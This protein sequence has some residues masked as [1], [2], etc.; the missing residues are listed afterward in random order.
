MQRRY[1]LDWLRVFAFALLMLFHTGMMFSTWDWHVKNLETSETFDQVMRWVHQWRMPLLFFISGSAVWF[2]MDHYST[3]RFFLERQKRLLLP[4]VF[5]MLVVIPPQVYFERLYHEQQYSSFWDFYPTI[6]STGSYPE[7]NLS[8]HHLWYVPYIWAYSMLMF[9]LFVCLRS[10]RGRKLLAHGLGWLERPWWLF[11]LFVPSAVSDLL[12]RPFWPSDQMNLLNDWANFSH[13]LSFFVVGFLL[14]SGTPVY[15]VIARHRNKFLCAGIAAFGLLEPVWMGHW[16]FPGHGVWA[17]RL[18]YNFHIWMWLLTALGYGRRYLSFNHRSLRYANEAVYPFYILHQTVIVILAYYLAYRNWSIASKFAVVAS[19]TFLVTWGLYEFC[20]KRWSLLRVSFGMKWAARREP[21]N[22]AGTTPAQGPILPVLR[23]SAVLVLMATTGF[24]VLSGCSAHHGKLVIGTL[25]ARSLEGNLLGM[26]SKQ[27]LAIYLPPSYSE[28]SA[29]RFP[30]L[31][32]L[33]NFTV[34]L[35]RYTGGSFQGFHLREAMD[36]QIQNGAAG[37]MIVVLPNALHFLGG[38]WYKTSPLTGDWDGY[39][40]HDL[41]QYVDSHFRTI[42]AAASRG[43]AGHGMGGTGAVELALRHP[44]VFGCVYALSPAVFDGNA[45]RDAGMLSERHLEHWR[46]AS[47][48]WAPL[49]ENARRKAFRDFIQT[50]LNSP[51]RARFWE[52]LCIS[53]AAAVSP[54][55]TL[56]YPHIRF[57]SPGQPNDPVLWAR[58]ANGLGGWDQKLA[59]Y[60]AR[61][62]AL[63]AITIEYTRNDENGWIPRGAEHLSSLMSSLGVK[64]TL[65]AHDGGHESTLG[66]RLESAMIPA[67]SRELRH[68]AESVSLQ[69]VA[70]MA[71]TDHRC[72]G[73]SELD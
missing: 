71:H 28:D 1:D 61:G 53:Y 66:A 7:G 21:A 31:Y 69:V 51:S 42:R 60:R 55:L 58:Y 70:P 39:I 3:W 11:L 50:R 20:I 46:D 30:V 68:E 33:P 65:V 73:L 57:P 36:R 8:W 34:G 12:L 6:F 63:N 49:N 10:V 16:P 24:F 45:L 29:R 15:D 25:E 32:L 22:G 56:P 23:V 52:G 18:L 13:K 9:P 47:R 26:A 72:S 59:S 19:G 38:S 64:N 17:Y 37:E 2:A 4:L 5:G 54:D 27:H 43:V 41:V 48:T 40:A 44:D 62:C 67:L 35:Y 14:A